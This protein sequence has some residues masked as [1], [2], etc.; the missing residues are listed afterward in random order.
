ME[1]LHEQMETLTK[2]EEEIMG[3]FRRITGFFSSKPKPNSSRG[4][5][6]IWHSLE[7]AKS[8]MS[9]DEI[10]PAIKGLVEKGFLHLDH[11]K[12]IITLMD[13]GYRYIA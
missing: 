4:Y 11:N 7:L 2:H 8:T 10:A 12:G 13:K 5:D 3:C 9:V 6:Q 1:H